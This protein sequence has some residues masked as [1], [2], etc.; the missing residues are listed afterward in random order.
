MK[1][2]TPTLARLFFFF[3]CALLDHSYLYVPAQRSRA[4]AV[5]LSE[6]WLMTAAR[7]NHIVRECNILLS[8][9]PVLKHY[10]CLLKDSAT[11]SQIKT[12]RSLFLFEITSF[13]GAPCLWT[14]ITSC[15]V[16][17]FA[18]WCQ[19]ERRVLILHCPITCFHVSA[20]KDTRK[21]QSCAQS[22]LWCRF[23]Y[24]FLHFFY[25][26]LHPGLELEITYDNEF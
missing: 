4:A 8:S 15:S 14:G 18:L 17:F 26:F 5:E 22:N 10:A 20:W 21:K 12:A 23:L 7:L 9:Q 13:H 24:I 16:H 1:R 2:N 3:F 11:C 6:Q 25:T 19:T